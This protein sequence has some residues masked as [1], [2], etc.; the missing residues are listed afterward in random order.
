M[1]SRITIMQVVEDA[2][3][4]A[5]KKQFNRLFAK[6]TVRDVAIV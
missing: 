6:A 3:A 2:R 5:K 4:Q 1:I